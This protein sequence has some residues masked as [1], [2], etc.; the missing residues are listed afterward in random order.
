VSKRFS[1]SAPELVNRLLTRAA[2]LIF[3]RSHPPRHL[4][5]DPLSFPQ[6]RIY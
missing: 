2:L 6:S 4:G 3:V 1:F 5:G